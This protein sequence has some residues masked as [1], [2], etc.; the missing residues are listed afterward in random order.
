M[1]FQY[2]HVYTCLCIQSPLQQTI[3]RFYAH[4]TRELRAE[5][6]Y[7]RVGFFGG[8]PTFLK[9]PFPPP[10]LPTSRRPWPVLPQYIP[11]FLGCL[12]SA[13]TCVQSIHPLQ[14][15]GHSATAP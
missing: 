7:F 2:V 13:R 14:S 4:I 8:F 6:E 5:P 9:V 12:C 11:G 15:L 10:F 3:A 1:C